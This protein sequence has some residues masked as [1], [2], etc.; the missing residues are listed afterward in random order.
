MV[1]HGSVASDESGAALKQDQVNQSVITPHCQLTGG[2]GSAEDLENF[3]N[4]EHERNVI[5]WHF[6]A[7]SNLHA[8]HYL[9]MLNDAVM[10]RPATIHSQV[11]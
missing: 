8:A 7:S 5:Q 11:T 3:V 2:Q 6:T 10:V 9:A 1:A 4:A